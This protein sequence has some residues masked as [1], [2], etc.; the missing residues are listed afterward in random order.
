LRDNLTVGKTDTGKPSLK[1]ME[2]GRFENLRESVDSNFKGKV[3]VTLV[4]R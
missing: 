1:A 4:E 3:K 2:G